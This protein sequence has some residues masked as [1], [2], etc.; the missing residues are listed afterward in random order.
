MFMLRAPFLG[1]LYA[2]ENF[3][4]SIH[5]A[6]PPCPTTNLAKAG[7]SLHFNLV[8]ARFTRYA[9]NIDHARIIRSGCSSI[10]MSSRS[11]PLLR[12]LRELKGLRITFIETKQT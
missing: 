6:F 1:F 3:A 5:H 11:S 10:A 12:V 9:D 2:F 7:G 4:V 8:S